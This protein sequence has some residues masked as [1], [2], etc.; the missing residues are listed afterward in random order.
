MVCS[1]DAQVHWRARKRKNIQIN[2]MSISIKRVQCLQRIIYALQWIKKRRSKRIKMK[3]TVPS[4]DET[5]V[6]GAINFNFS[7]IHKLFINLLLCYLCVCVCFI[8]F[9]RFACRYFCIQFAYIDLAVLTHVLFTPVA[10]VAPNWTLI[11][12]SLLFQFKNLLSVLSQFLG[13][14]QFF[15]L[16]FFIRKG[17]I[18]QNSIKKR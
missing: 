16:F 17:E 7:I 2:L 18:I 13:C 3:A 5:D 12:L 1:V 6:I 14:R 8:H 4:K 11:M 15:F 10:S 9:H